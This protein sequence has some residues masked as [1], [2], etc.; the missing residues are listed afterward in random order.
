[1]KENRV[2]K[3]AATL[4]LNALDNKITDE[5]NAVLEVL[6][7]TAKTVVEGNGNYIEQMEAYAKLNALIEVTVAPKSQENI[8]D[9][10]SRYGQTHSL[11]RNEA[12]I[13]EMYEHEM[14][15]SRWQA[16]GGDIRFGKT[17]K[18]NVPVKFDTISAGIETDYRD[19][20][21]SPVAYLQDYTVELMKNINNNVALKVVTELVDN[22]K[23]AST[24]GKI[25]YYASSNGISQVALDEAIKLVRRTGEANIFGDYSVV[26]QLE[27]FV[28][29]TADAYKVLAEQRLLEIDNQGFIGR[30]RGSNVTEIKNAFDFYS[31][32]KGVASETRPFANFYNTLLPESDLFVMADGKFGPNHI[33]FRGGLTTQKGSNVPTGSELQRWDMEVATHFVAER[34]YMLGLIQDEDL[35]RE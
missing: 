5:T 16:E 13:I 12:A 17:S 4:L 28:G 21:D 15:G 18:V 20:I 7:E 6:K 34:A 26:T 2:T 9:V 23:A 14:R 35:V 25:V 10:M 22:I 31:I 3:Q 1:M 32:N 11:S 27:D 33:F 29:F 24:A 8:T 19:L 30:Y